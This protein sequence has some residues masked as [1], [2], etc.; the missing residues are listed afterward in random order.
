M[1]VH[2]G[3]V[4]SIAGG[5]GHGVEAVSG[6][7]GQRKSWGDPLCEVSQPSLKIRCGGGQALGLWC[8]SALLPHRF[9]RK[10]LAKSRPIKAEA[11]TSK[12]EGGKRWRMEHQRASGAGGKRPEDAVAVRLV[13]RVRIC[14]HS[15]MSLENA[16]CPSWEENRGEGVGTFRSCF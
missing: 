6:L 2:S 4:L 14:S 16:A 9:Q 15:E 5:V 8:L 1:F 3:A 10:G 11:H 7:T 12:A 13:P